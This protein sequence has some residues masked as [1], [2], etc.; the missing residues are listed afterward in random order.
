MGV[1][2]VIINFHHLL[3]SLEQCLLFIK[4]KQPTV[5]H[6]LQG[7]VSGIGSSPDL[8]PLSDLL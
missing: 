5:I 1:P 8:S 4:N 2:P 7:R 6:C 3:T